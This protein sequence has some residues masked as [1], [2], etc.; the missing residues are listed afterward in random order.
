MVN[1][2]VFIT[3][4]YQVDVYQQILCLSGVFEKNLDKIKYS[5]YRKFTEN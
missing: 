1:N 2:I 4:D 5:F 3:V